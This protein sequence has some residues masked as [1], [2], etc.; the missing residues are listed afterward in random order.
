M[1]GCG[2]VG[3]WETEAQAEWQS[4][5][6]RPVEALMSGTMSPDTL[7]PQN[8]PPAHPPAHPASYPSLSPAEVLPCPCP[9]PNHS[10]AS[11]GEGGGGGG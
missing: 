3:G 10:R 2:W 5:M 6:G 4:Q 1:G 9:P 7:S 8:C 11:R